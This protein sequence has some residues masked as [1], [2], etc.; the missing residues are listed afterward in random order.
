MTLHYLYFFEQVCRYVSLSV[1]MSWQ[2]CAGLE[3]AAYFTFEC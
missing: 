1:H 3:P 2:L